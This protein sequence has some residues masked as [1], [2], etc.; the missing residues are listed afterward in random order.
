MNR[1][2]KALSY[3]SDHDAGGLASYLAVDTQNLR[4]FSADENDG[5]V[6]AFTIN[7]DTGSLAANGAATNDRH[8]VYLSLSPDNQ[9]LFGAN[10]Q[11]GSVDVYPIDGSGQ[12]GASIQTLSTGTNAHCIVMD[13]TSRVLVANKGGDTISRF[14]YSGGV[15]TPQ[16]PATTAS[17]S[18]RHITMGPD[19]RA[20]VVSEEEDTIT[21]YTVAGDGQLSVFWEDSRLPEGGNAG[22]DTGA[23]IRV[24][25]DG[26]FVYAT[27]RGNS[28]TIVAYDISTGTRQFI[29]HEGTQGTIPRSMAMDPRGEFLL[30]GNRGDKKVAVFD[31][32]ADGS[33]TSAHTET[34]APIPYFVTLV[35]L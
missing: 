3:V 31:I 25:P 12:V 7:P 10:Y 18:P 19:G 29:E 21:S 9:Y 20:Y 6:L 34:V 28:N 23:D 17:G 11:E 24:T 5:G 1:T 4:L 14:N 8:P 35:D 30:V 22:S 16:V 13:G 33:L 2:T 15:L 32:E 27:N 26:K